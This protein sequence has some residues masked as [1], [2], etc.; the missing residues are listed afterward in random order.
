MVEALPRRLRSVQ[1]GPR[2]RPWATARRAAGLVR[3][4]RGSAPE[5]GRLINQYPRATARH[6]VAAP[7]CSPRHVRALP[8]YRLRPNARLRLTPAKRRLQALL[9]PNTR[10]EQG[11]PRP[12]AGE[13]PRSAGRRSRGSESQCSPNKPLPLIDAGAKHFVSL[14]RLSPRRPLPDPERVGD[15]WAILLQ[16]KTV[17]GVLPYVSRP[18]PHGRLLLRIR[19]LT[20][21]IRPSLV[22][23]RSP[24]DARC[25]MKGQCSADFDRPR[26]QQHR[27]PHRMPPRV[28][29]CRGRPSWRLTAPVLF[30]SYAASCSYRFPGGAIATQLLRY[31]GWPAAGRACC[32]QTRPARGAILS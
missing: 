20:R 32:R 2:D 24:G 17:V 25:T 7:G 30:G 15:G 29:P 11:T 22:C 19:F 27:Q 4:S 18:L 6:R 12:C 13:F 3:L 23:K 10:R 26:E 14:S 28:R 21:Y 31:A 9:N 16:E 5:N 8:T 1:R